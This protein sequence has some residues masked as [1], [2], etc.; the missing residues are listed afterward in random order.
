MRFAGGVLF[1]TAGALF[2]TALA[3]VAL[4][5]PSAYTAIALGTLAFLLAIGGI[6]GTLQAAKSEDVLNIETVAYTIANELRELVRAMH[7]DYPS[8]KPDDKK[9]RNL[10]LDEFYRERYLVR[11]LNVGRAM[12]RHSLYGADAL[13]RVADSPVNELQIIRIYNGLDRLASELREKNLE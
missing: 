7:A 13:I 12:K 6:V 1:T 3:I 10:F 11:V 8:D 9:T 2:A 4:N 5:A